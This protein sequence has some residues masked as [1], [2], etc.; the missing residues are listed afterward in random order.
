MCVENSKGTRCWVK[1]P[2]IGC[3]VRTYVVKKRKKDYSDLTTL[4]VQHNHE[5]VS[6]S[7]LSW[8]QR[9][10]HITAA[11]RNQKKTLNVFGVRPS[12]TMC[13][14]SN[15]KC[16]VSNVGFGNQNVRNVVRDVREK[17]VTS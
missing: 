7:K 15:M 11:T 9:E 14:F 13:L 5:V 8:I 4:E 6:P 2:R 16:G 1:L 17:K 12:Q 3:K 10:R